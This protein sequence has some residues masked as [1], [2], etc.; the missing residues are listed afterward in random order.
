VI[1]EGISVVTTTWNERENIEELVSAIH[2]VLCKYTHEI[3]VVDDNSSDGTFEVAK[4]FAD[5]AVKKCREGQSK[6][7][8]SGMQLAK[9]SAVVTIDADLE[10]DPKYI[11]Q[12]LDLLYDSDL[13]VASR[14]DI[15]R[16]SEK[17]AS[18]T[19]GRLLGVEDIFSNFRAFRKDVVSQFSL[20][21][22]ETFG[23]VFLVVAKKKG[24][25]VGELMYAPPARRRNPR[26]GGTLKANFRILWALA[27]AFVLYLFQV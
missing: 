6:G 5:V 21:G 11:P 15:P 26:I 1:Q 24:M 2:L 22:G 20:M 3:I 10:N 25:I 4:Q 23:A 18:K 17:L 14:T 27:R 9:Y 19:L 16:F 7:L 8:L 12:M 13:V